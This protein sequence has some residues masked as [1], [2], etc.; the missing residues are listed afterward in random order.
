MVILKVLKLIKVCFI[1]GFYVFLDGPMED[2]FKVIQNL[3]EMIEYINYSTLK[4]KEIE[5]E[6]IAAI[7]KEAEEKCSSKLDI[8]ISE[9]NKKCNS[10]KILLKNMKITTDEMKNSNKITSSDVKIRENL[11]MTHTTKFIEVLKSFQKAQQNFKLSLQ[12]KI[13]RQIKIVKPDVTQE[14]IQKIF[15]IG[16]ATQVFQSIIL[17]SKVDPISTAYT[18]A[19]DKYQDIVKLEKSIVE[20]HQMFT[21]MAILVTQ[22]GEMLNKI[23]YSIENA[24]QYVEKGNRE[25]VKANKTRRKMRKKYFLIGLVVMAVL[26]VI[27]LPSLTS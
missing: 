20:L 6:A 5:Q 25:L 21:D 22:Q 14:E 17:N 1:V 15:E 4:T 27:L 10:C 7:G 13:E 9:T 16:D 11:H 26:V 19:V 3:Q 12:N 18:N 24:E 23:E 2:F 8:L